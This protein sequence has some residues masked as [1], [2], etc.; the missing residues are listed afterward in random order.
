[1]RRWAV[2][3]ALD[4]LE[5]PGCWIVE[6]AQHGAGGDRRFIASN[7]LLQRLAWCARCDG[8]GSDEGVGVAVSDHLEVEVVGV[9]AAG[10]HRVQLLLGLLPGQQA[11][12]RVS[13]DALGGMDGAGVAETGR[14]AHIVKRQPNGQPAAV[15]PHSQV[16][17]PA[18][19]GDGPAVAVFNPVGGG[20]PESAVV[21]AGDDHISDTR[22]IAVGQTHLGRGWGVVE[23]ML[24]GAPVEF[25]DKLAGG[26]KHDGVK[27]G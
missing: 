19:A 14:G 16:T 17:A 8:V 24:S 23:A 13:G 15:V 11:V 9:P 3:V 25:G 21:A 12:H 27:S 6:L 26:G 10:E 1:M 4:R 20:E 2:G 18:D 7:D 5:Q 22:L